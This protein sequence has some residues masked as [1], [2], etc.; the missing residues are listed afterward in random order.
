MRDV[1]F[2]LGRIVAGKP[3]K[4]LI[5]LMLVLML[6]LFAVDPVAAVGPDRS[7]FSHGYARAWAEKY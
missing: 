7:N 6:L 1:T 2:T 3:K 5:M 4:V